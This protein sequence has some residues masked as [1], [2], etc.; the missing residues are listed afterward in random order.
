MDQH[1]LDIQHRG[2]HAYREQTAP[3]D[4]CKELDRAIGSALHGAEKVDTVFRDCTVHTD[5]I[6]Q[7]EQALPYIENA[8]NQNRQFIL[9]QGETV[10]LEKAR[11]VS[12]ESVEHL[13]RH[14]ELITSDP[15]QPEKIYITENVDTHTVYE[16]RFL[17]TLLRY[18]E[19]FVGGRY[20]K[21]KK[22]SAS[23]TSDISFARQVNTPQR[24]MEFRLTFQETAQGSPSK[25]T[26]DAMVRMQ[27]I[28]QTVEI[29]LRTALMKEVSAAPVLK[30]PIARTNVLLHDPNFR[31]AFE[32][33]SY[34]TEYTADGYETLEP[35]R[36]CGAPDAQL[37]QDLSSLVSITSYLSYCS[38]LRQ[39]LENRR[40]EA[41]REEN[42]K[43]LEQL[44]AAL[45]DVSPAALAYIQGLE[46]QLGL[47]EEKADR[48]RQETALRHAAEEK[49]TAANSQIRALQTDSAKLN[50][51]ICEKNDEIRS[52]S[53]QNAEIRE[54]VE[55][56]LRHAELQQEKLRKHFE[57][58][59][60]QK[61]QEFQL[62]YDALAEQ[63]RLASA[64]G[65]D[66]TQTCCT[67]EEFGALEQEFNAFRRY[68][69]QQWKLTKKQIRK[70]HLW[71]K[72]ET[73][74][75]DPNEE[76]R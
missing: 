32:L 52:L 20:Q 60:E 39:E 56:R 69:K 38:G 25:Q 42:R 28:L 22:L 54:S 57:E 16:N 74:G 37:R 8:L 43:K 76:K 47:L 41:V 29:F 46:Q 58:L 53:Q 23:F 13:S 30:P 49:L 7:I 19:D 5:W 61:Q 64:M 31:V 26:A 33:Y 44:R 4:A 68:Y 55:L 2:F 59:L 50:S 63:Y 40:K 71:T 72:K 70:D 73:K 18:I 15:Q 34:L 11:R 48:L 35:F 10:P 36:T 45:G 21:I 62:Q 17:Y 12:R 3:D 67:K 14:S 27:T 66:L 6:Q 75:D 24:Q 51:I 9:R 1:W 65:R